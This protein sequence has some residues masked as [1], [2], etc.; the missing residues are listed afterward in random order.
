MTPSIN[1]ANTSTTSATASSSLPFP[2]PPISY[3]PIA[4]TASIKNSKSQS[5]TLIVTLSIHSSP[6]STSPALPL[7]PLVLTGITSSLFEDLSAFFSNRSDIVI[8]GFNPFVFLQ[9]YLQNPKSRWWRQPPI[10]NRVWRPWRSVSIL[11]CHQQ[12]LL[13]QLASCIKC[14]PFDVFVVAY[15]VIT[16]SNSSVYCNICVTLG[17]KPWGVA[18]YDVQ[19]T[20]IA[21]QRKGHDDL[22]C[23]CHP[24]SMQEKPK[25]GLFLRLCTRVVLDALVLY[26]QNHYLILYSLFSSQSR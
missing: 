26:I 10:G 2:P 13:F 1:L 5:L 4:T 25:Q 24:F 16:G 18:L 7:F 11:W 22:T 19:V 17:G 20:E 23:I 8:D 12:R 14:S 15:S 3:A 9:N 6:I 21:Q